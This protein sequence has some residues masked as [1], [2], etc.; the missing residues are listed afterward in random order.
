MHVYIND[1]K[2]WW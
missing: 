1:K 2:L